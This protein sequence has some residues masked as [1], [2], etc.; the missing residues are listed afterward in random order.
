[1]LTNIENKVYFI[2]KVDNEIGKV[3]QMICKKPY[4]IQSA[5]LACYMELDITMPHVYITLMFVKTLV[6]WIESDRTMGYMQQEIERALQPQDITNNTRTAAITTPTTTT[7]ATSTTSTTL[8]VPTRIESPLTI[9]TRL[10]ADMLAQAAISLSD[11]IPMVNIIPLLPKRARH[12]LSNVPETNK[13]RKV[14]YDLEHYYACHGITP[15]CRIKNGEEEWVKQFEMSFTLATIKYIIEEEKKITNVQYVGDHK[16]H[17]RKMMKKAGE[18]YPKLRLGMDTLLTTRTGAYRGKIYV[19]SD[20]ALLSNPALTLSPDPS[21]N[22]PTPSTQP[23]TLSTAGSCPVRPK[24][25]LQLK[26]KCGLQANPS[27]LF[28]CQQLRPALCSALDWAKEEYKATGAL[29]QCKQNRLTLS[30]ANQAIQEM[31]LKLYS[32]INRF[33]YYGDGNKFLPDPHYVRMVDALLLD[34]LSPLSYAVSDFYAPHF[35]ASTYCDMLEWKRTEPAKRYL[36]M[37]QGMVCADF[38]FAVT[39][40]HAKLQKLHYLK[41]HNHLFQ[42]FIALKE[43]DNGLSEVLNEDVIRHLLNPPAFNTNPL[44]TFFYTI[45]AAKFLEIVHLQTGSFGLKY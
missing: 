22:N 14:V 7:T 24:C 11:A 13:Q 36:Q 41:R 35:N 21:I 42:N 17:S 37:H 9:A 27:H 20:N 26:C 8:T 31:E 5:Q 39:D 33:R 40:D 23:S 15:D 6:G 30:K 18:F 32:Q 38:A 44:I 2:K 28:S 25:E 12:V 3:L 43:S 1:M 29:K 19:S 4:S 16:V 34:P 10:V 45:W